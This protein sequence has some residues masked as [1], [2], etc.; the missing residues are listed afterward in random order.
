MEIMV[1]GEVTKGAM[2][3]GLWLYLT[4][5]F[6]MLVNSQFNV[7]LPP[8]LKQAEHIL[9]FQRLPNPQNCEIGYVF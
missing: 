7:S 4:L 9:A 8:D 1:K 5:S 2:L 3:R 6:D